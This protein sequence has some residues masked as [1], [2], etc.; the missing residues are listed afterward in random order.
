M[1]IKRTTSGANT[2]T[3]QII[4][5]LTY[6][7]YNVWRQNTVGVYDQRRGV[8]RK[9]AN[10]KKGV[11]DIIGFDPN[12]RFVAI[13]IKIGKDKLSEEQTQFLAEVQAAG[14]L[15]IVAH[16]LEDFWE[17]FRLK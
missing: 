10:T 7:R 14:G 12:G 17:K 8:F 13:E 2:V 4:R 3:A 9:N 15:A 5:Y 11:S 1:T 6:N 16:S